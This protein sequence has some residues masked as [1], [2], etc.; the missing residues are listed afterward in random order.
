MGTAL[1]GCDPTKTGGPQLRSYP[2]ARQE[3]PPAPPSPQ[4]LTGEASAAGGV[5]SGGHGRRWQLALS[6]AEGHR[7]QRAR[8]G[9]GV[10][11]TLGGSRPG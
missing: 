5:R 3:A 1:L 9:S 10:G 6:L 4:C 11:T 7:G 8:P 2:E